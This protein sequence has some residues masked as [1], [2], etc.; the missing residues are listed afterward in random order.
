MTGIVCPQYRTGFYA[1]KRGGI[2]K[3]PSL[4][5]GCIGAWA[6]C[7][8]PTGLA[9]RDW[10]GVGNHGTLANMDPATD[11]VASYGNYALDFDGSNDQVFIASANLETVHAISFWIKTTANNF[12]AIGGAS[13]YYALYHDGSN[14]YYSAVAGIFV[15]VSNSTLSSGAW[16][17]YTVN[18]QNTSVSFWI[19]GIQVGTT[20]TL[21]SSNALEVAAF[22]SYAAGNFAMAGQ[23]DDIAFYKRMLSPKEIALRASRPGI[24]YDLA[25]RRRSR[26]FGGFKAAWAARKALI[27]MAGST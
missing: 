9:L 26:V 23:L 5:R 24:A 15:A 2:P 3:Y 25:P 13:G 16:R 22:G 4:W 12:V 1:P 11:W 10:S 14:L 7:L 18:R 17:H 19:D 27:Q 8:G 21:A 6:P 20:Q